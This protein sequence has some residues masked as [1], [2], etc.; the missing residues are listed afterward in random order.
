MDV[1]NPT[2]LI[3]SGAMMLRHL[4]WDDAAGVLESAILATYHDQKVTQDLARVMN[5]KPLK[6]SEFGQ[7]II[8]RMKPVKK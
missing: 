6:C 8:K 5:I 4:E 2:S 3:L 1:A 7:E